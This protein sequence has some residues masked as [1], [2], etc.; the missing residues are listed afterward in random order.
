MDA[1][2]SV[3]LASAPQSAKAR[4]PITAT[5]DFTSAL[6]SA[7]QYANAASPMLVTDAGITTFSRR[8]QS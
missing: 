8:S 1:V 4:A 7:S 6:A 2:G 3:T 5:G